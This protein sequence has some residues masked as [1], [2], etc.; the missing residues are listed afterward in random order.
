[1]GLESRAR[2]CHAVSAQI[3][4][5][6]AGVRLDYGDPGA[7][8]AFHDDQR[9]KISDRRRLALIAA[10]RSVLTLRVIADHLEISDI[11]KARIDAEL[12][13]IQR[14]LE[15]R[16]PALGLNRPQGLG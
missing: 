13:T 10:E 1:M 3:E 14:E 15:V 7:K 8:H 11:G 16:R 4:F 6:H 2:S 9:L 12:D 5:D